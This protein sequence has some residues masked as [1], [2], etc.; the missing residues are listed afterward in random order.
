M[1]ILPQNY[2]NRQNTF[3]P[4]EIRRTPRRF[5]RLDAEIHIHSHPGMYAISVALYA[6][7]ALVDRGRLILTQAE[8]ASSERAW[9]GG[10]N[11]AQRLAHEYGAERLFVRDSHP[12]E[13]RHKAA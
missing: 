12:V 7:H 3:G 6:G 1:G 2:T 10:Y 13:R 5:S 9:Q 8:C 4:L 11:L